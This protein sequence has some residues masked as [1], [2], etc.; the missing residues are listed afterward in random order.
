MYAK[1]FTFLLTCWFACLANLG[2][3]QAQSRFEIKGTVKGPKG[4]TLAAAIQLVKDSSQVLVKVEVSDAHGAFTFS[5]I[6]AGN[7][8]LMAMHYDYAL[9][10]SGA[11]RLQSNTDLGEVVMPKR[12]VALKEVKIEAQKPFVEQHFDKTVLNVENSISAAGSNVLWRCWRK[13]GLNGRPKRQHQHAGPRRSDGDDQW[14]AG[15]HVRHRIGD[16]AAQPQRQRGGE[17]RFD[18]QPLGQV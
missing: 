17:D 18:Y 6:P 3:A 4:E 15:A 5:N 1:T 8:K 12:A 10:S 13:P 7:Y 9:Y 2:H 16:H 11:V 14:Q